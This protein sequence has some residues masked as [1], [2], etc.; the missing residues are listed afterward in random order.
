MTTLIQYVRRDIADLGKEIAHLDR[1][2]SG[3]SNDAEI[4]AGAD[5]ASQAQG[6][7]ITAGRLADA[8]EAE[9]EVHQL[10]RTI[11]RMDPANDP[12][13]PGDW[14]ETLVSLISWARALRTAGAVRPAPGD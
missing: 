14:R 4:E 13:D 7:A 11:A 5:V 2:A 9:A 3:D 12:S 6:L 1:T 10:V 8:Y